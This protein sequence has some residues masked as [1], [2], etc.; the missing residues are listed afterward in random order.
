[1]PRYAERGRFRRDLVGAA[2]GQTFNFGAAFGRTWGRE[3]G[4]G[5]A[6]NIWGKNWTPVSYTGGK[7]KKGND[8]LCKLRR[9]NGIVL[10]APYLSSTNWDTKQRKLLTEV[11]FESAHFTILH[12]LQP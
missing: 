11:I 4:I 12:I 9:I 6:N 7:K 5:A 8:Y 10:K 3:G 2:S 1:M